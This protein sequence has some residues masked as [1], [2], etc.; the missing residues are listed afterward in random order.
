[1]NVHVNISLSLSLC[2]CMCLYVHTYMYIY[3]RICIHIYI[4]ML[5]PPIDLGFLVCLKTY[6]VHQA[7]YYFLVLPVG[8]TGEQQDTTY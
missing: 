1:M 6:A 3:I 5:P 7:G 8:L 4:Y 2:M